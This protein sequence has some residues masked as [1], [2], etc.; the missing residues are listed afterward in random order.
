MLMKGKIGIITG[1]NSGI[2]EATVRQLR[3]RGC[4]V[5]EFS[6]RAAEGGS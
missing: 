3:E 2:G 6:R 4:T 5:Y 1:G